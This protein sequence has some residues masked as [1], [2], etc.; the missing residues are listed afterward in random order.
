M[1]QLDEKVKRLL[2]SQPLWYV[3]TYS[4]EPNV[5]II[6]FKEVLDDGRLLLCDVFMNHTLKNIKANGKVCVTVCDPDNMEA[7]SVF[8]KAEY[9]SEGELLDGWKPLAS[10]MSGGKLK[11]KGVVLITPEKVRVMSASPENGKEL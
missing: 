4:D 11:P 6:G 8:G 10:A 5:S 3:G 7:Y 1:K 2:E 9:Q